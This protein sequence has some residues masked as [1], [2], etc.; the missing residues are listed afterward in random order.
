M[1]GHVSIYEMLKSEDKKDNG[2]YI[3]MVLEEEHI[4]R[5]LTMWSNALEE[6]L[7]Y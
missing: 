7:T 3:A 5:L 4:G 1:K 6:K 2:I